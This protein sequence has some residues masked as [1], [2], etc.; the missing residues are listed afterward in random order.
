M[1]VTL[2]SN[3]L[4]EQPH[5]PVRDALPIAVIRP[6]SGWQ[7]LDVGEIWQFRDLL[8]MLGLR[9]ITLR[10][11]QTALGVIWVLL[12]PLLAAGIFTFVFGRVARLPSDG[13]PYFVFSFAGL[14]GWNA[15]SNTLAKASSSLLGNINLVQKVYFPRLILPLATVFSSLVD[16]V[17]ALGM[18]ACLLLSNHIALHA[19]LL[20]L[21]IW[22]LMALLQAVG[23]GLILAALTVSYRD[24][25]YVL[26]I[27]IQ[28][29]LYAS[30]V[31]Y[32]L[33]V[34]H[35]VP[36]GLR[37]LYYL[38]PMVGVLEG[39]RWSLLGLHT[40]PWGAAAYSMLCG[41]AVFVIGGFA[42]KRMER[43][44]ADVI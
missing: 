5:E 3:K 15:F 32:S 38:N 42:F 2:P 43:R 14:M 25:Q 37:T 21:P 41:I 27:V 8:Y 17:V 19:G 36:A 40:M 24:V 29:A 26:P 16:F 4:S 1:T 28:F 9:D 12:Q 35:R 11:R 7:A 6:A 13:I 23:F 18:M 39:F 31:A 22:L 20:M 34:L 30:P 44:F 33:S 10:Y